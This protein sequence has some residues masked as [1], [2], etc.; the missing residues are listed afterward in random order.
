MVNGSYCQITK[1]ISIVGKITKY[2]RERHAIIISDKM[3]IQRFV[4]NQ[5][6]ITIAIDDSIL[7]PMTMKA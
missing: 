5:L 4:G 3:D 6:K 7:S 1:D 2:S